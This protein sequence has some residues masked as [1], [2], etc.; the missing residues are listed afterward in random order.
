MGRWSKKLAP[1]FI[2]FVGLA[3][4]EKVLDVGCGTGS[5]TFA[6]TTLLIS[7]RSAPSIIR[8]SS[9]RQQNGE[10]PIRTFPSSRRMPA[11]CRGRSQVSRGPAGASLPDQRPTNGCNM[12]SAAGTMR[13]RCVLA[14]DLW[15]HVGERHF[16]LRLR[17][18]R[19]WRGA[20]ARRTSKS[21]RPLQTIKPLALE[22]NVAPKLDFGKGQEAALA[23]QVLAQSGVILISWQHE[24]IGEIARNLVAGN[25]PKATIPAQWPGDR[26][27]IV[28]VFDRPAK[29]KSR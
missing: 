16:D 28:W 4:G 15:V 27:D 18:A 10:T 5:L 7:A 22:L 20:G 8:L 19:S 6:L 17:P 29:D 13:R 23:K 1:L 2:D 25:G 14:R 3:D 11:R 21:K 9:S 26:F 24:A 12:S